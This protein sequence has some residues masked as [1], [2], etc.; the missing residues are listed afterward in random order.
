MRNLGDHALAA[1]EGREVVVPA[2]PRAYRV[3]LPGWWWAGRAFKQL[4]ERRLPAEFVQ[5]SWSR[6]GI[7]L[8]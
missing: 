4:A 6:V 5:L 1:R 3:P 7:L 2:L 8:M